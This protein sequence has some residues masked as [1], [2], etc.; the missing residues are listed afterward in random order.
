MTVQHHRGL[1]EQAADAVID[2]ACR[3]LR[4]H[5]V[6][7]Q[8]PDPATTSA[9][10]QMTYR[11][12]LTELLMAEYDDRARRRSEHRIKAAG[13]PRQKA[14]RDVDANSP[15]IH[16]LASCGWIK[17]GRPLCLIDDSGTG[18]SHLLIAQG[19]EA[20][21]ADFRVK[22]VL[23]TKLVNVLVE[24]AGN[25]QLTK[26]IARYGRADLP[27]IHELRYRERDRGDAELPFQVRTEREEN[28]SVERLFRRLEQHLHHPRL[29]AA[30]VDRLAFGGNLIE[31]G[32]D[33]YDLA[34][35]KNQQAN[36]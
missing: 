6:R 19:T 31:T 13:F 11:G 18:T 20:A 23:A 9:H 26:T 22:Y 32:T 2:T 5:T 25:K 7:A 14:L 10:E 17:K 28:A 21:M 16:I 12:F 29:S 24:A 33:S 15:T 1:T 30:I 34:H 4:L 35:T 27:A 3:M 36:G 8:F